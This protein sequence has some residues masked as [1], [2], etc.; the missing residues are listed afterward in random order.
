M[1]IRYDNPN[2]LYRLIGRHVTTLAEMGATDNELKQFFKK[3]GDATFMDFAK[4][5]CAHTHYIQ[6]NEDE[7]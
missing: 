1:K 2:V 5:E 7:C 6:E 3:G 4:I